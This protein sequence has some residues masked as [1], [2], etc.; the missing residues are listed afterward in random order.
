MGLFYVDTSMDN[1]LTKQKEHA[2]EIKA[3]AKECIKIGELASRDIF[4]KFLWEPQL[5]EYE[6]DDYKLRGTC[7]NPN[8]L[9][10]Y[11]IRRKYSNYWDYI[12]AMDAY[13]DYVSYIDSAYGSFEMMKNAAD[14]GMSIIYIPKKPK[15]T[16]KKS[17][18]NLIKSGFTPSRI[19][20]DFITD[21]DLVQNAIDELSIKEVSYDE[22]DDY[23]LPKNIAKLH[24]REVSSKIKNERVSSIYAS[25]SSGY[26]QGMDAIINFLNNP[27]TDQIE[28]RGRTASSFT[29]EMENLHEFD[30][31]P[32]DIVD[33]MFAPTTSYISSS[34]IMNP[35]KQR[36]QNILSALTEAGFNFLDKS[37]T[38]GMDKEVVRA[39]TR[40]Y[41]N[42]VTDYSE[43][44]PKQLK[45][46]KK[47]EAKK[48]KRS[49]ERLIGD[50]RIQDVLLRNRAH[51][52][53]DNNL[54]FSIKDVIPED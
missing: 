25:H 29:E 27:N 50:R 12:D 33:E 40:K 17:N 23:E 2:E 54:N 48:R 16:N 14:N 51:F 38:S 7:T 1:S 34:Y 19:I 49:K 21:D 36:Q 26:A 53:M 4:P 31:L 15:L 24:N 22:D 3:L 42:Y 32:K 8:V 5:N 28:N 44:T 11:T 37:A 43:L 41:S 30:Y 52:S 13:L 6:G 47:K 9:K 20:E 45:K 18:K 39:V 35:E 10:A 46:L